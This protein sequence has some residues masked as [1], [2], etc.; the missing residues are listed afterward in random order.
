[1]KRLAMFSSEKILCEIIAFD[2][3]F[4]LNKELKQLF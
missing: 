3:Y 2:S 1:M 4:V